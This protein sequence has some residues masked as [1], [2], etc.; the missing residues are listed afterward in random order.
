MKT[1]SLTYHFTSKQLLL[2]TELKRNMFREQD[3][4]TLTA[5]ARLLEINR[6]AYP[7]LTPDCLILLLTLLFALASPRPSTCIE[8]SSN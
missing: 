3:D 4:I 8:C 1:L 2:L 5:S 7:A 6:H